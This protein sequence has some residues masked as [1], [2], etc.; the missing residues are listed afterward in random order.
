[1]SG[2]TNCGKGGGSVKSVKDMA[3]F[4]Q[5]TA[6]EDAKKEGKAGDEGQGELKADFKQ[7]KF[8]KTGDIQLNDG[9]G[10]CQLNK[11][12]HTNDK[13]NAGER[14]DGPCT[15]KGTDIFKIGERWKPQTDVESQHK[16]VLFPPRRKNMCTSNLE[17]L[18]TMINVMQVRE[19]MAPAQEKEQ[20]YLK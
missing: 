6:N 4:F 8:G 7:A 9:D 19:L 20:T 1:M 2:S 12:T 11:Q 5:S 3:M 18:Q 13:R 15:G 14:T 16:E 17:N 10:V